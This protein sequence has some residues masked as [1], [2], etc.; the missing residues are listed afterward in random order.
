MISFKILGDPQAQERPRFRVIEMKGKAVPVAYDPKKS[1]AEKKRIAQ[2]VTVMYDPDTKRKIYF[3]QYIPLRM[4]LT[5]IMPRPKSLP[6]KVIEHVRKPDLD[7][8]VKLVKDALSKVL[9]H[10]D[11]QIV[12]I[13]ALKRYPVSG[14]ETGTLIEIERI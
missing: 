5:F 11:A 3:E 8:L 12:E 13:Q 14:E 10:D 2:L 6:K 1:K 9:Y 7:K 4:S